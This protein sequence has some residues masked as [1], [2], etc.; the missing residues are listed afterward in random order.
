MARLSGFERI[1]TNASSAHVEY[2]KS[3][4]AHIVL[5]RQ[6]QS[7]AHDFGHA[8][9][10][11]SGLTLPFV[12]DSIGTA[13]TLMLGVNVLQLAGAAGA[14]LVRPC[15][16]I[17]ED[18]ASLAAGRG[19]VVPREVAE[20]SQ[21]GNKVA[22]KAILGLGSLPHLRYLSEPLSKHLGG[23]DGYL[24]NGDFTPNRPVVVPGGLEAVEAA[25]LRNKQ[26]VSGKKVV[27]RLCE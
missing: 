27:I 23:E 16:G 3:L 18:F 24:A 12:F 17:V 4:G 5:D 19:G 14:T 11:D 26:G 2:L 1:I 22:I 20:Q 13:A 8:L 15:G 21:Q 7:A 9:G 6:T 10:N 25:L